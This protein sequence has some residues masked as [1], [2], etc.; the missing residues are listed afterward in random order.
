[1]KKSGNVSRVSTDL[2]TDLVLV[3]KV[4]KVTQ[5]WESELEQESCG[6]DHHEKMERSNNPV[7]VSIEERIEQKNDNHGSKHVEERYDGES[8][9]FRRSNRTRKPIARF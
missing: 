7:E 2:V 1:M 6:D 3:Y 4:E 8:T 9:T 5:L